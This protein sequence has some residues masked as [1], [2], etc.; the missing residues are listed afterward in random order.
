M[1]AQIIPLIAQFDATDMTHGETRIV[2]KSYGW[3]AYAVK[4]AGDR[5]M[6]TRLSE[7]T[8]Q[9]RLEQYR[10]ATREQ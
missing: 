6:A 9:R 5:V 3:K 7:K 1:S 4:L 10:Q 8:I 2:A